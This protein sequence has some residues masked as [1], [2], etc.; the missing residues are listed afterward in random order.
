MRHGTQGH[1]ANR[2]GPHEGHVAHR[3]RTRGRRPRVSTRTPVRAPRGERGWRVRVLGRGHGLV[4]PGDSIGAVTQR[5][6]RGPLFY[7]KI[8]PF[9]L[10]VGLS[11]CRV[12]PLRA[13]WMHDKCQMR[14]D[15]GDRVDRSPRDHQ[16]R[17]VLKNQE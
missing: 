9:F 7:R 3:V 11:S 17:H 13:T 14:S 5:R 2:A 10:C 6:Y 16:S 4:G 15:G 8:F 12:L 1:V